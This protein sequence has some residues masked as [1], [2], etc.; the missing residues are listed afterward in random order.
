M[1]VEVDGKMALRVDYAHHAVLIATPRFWNSH[2]IHYMNVSLSHTHGNEGIMGP[3]APDSWLPKLRSG[4]SVGPK[5]T[6]L[7]DRFKALYKVFAESWRVTDE[8]SLFTYAPGT[9]TETFTDR[10]YPAL[11][12]PCTVK[13]QFELPVSPLPVNIDPE[14]AKQVCAGVTHPGLFQD[15]VF[16]VVTTGDKSFADGYLAEQKFK[17]DGTA[18]HV[19][20]DEVGTPGSGKI[21]ITVVVLG[22]RACCPVQRG[23]VTIYINGRAVDR[24]VDFDEVGRACVTLEDLKPGEYKISASYRR[25]KE[26]PYSSSTSPLVTYIVDKAITNEV[27]PI[28]RTGTFELKGTADGQFMFN[29]KAPNNEIILT[30]ERY[31]TKASAK[32]GIASVKKNAA[33]DERYDRRKSKS[34]QPYFVLQA[35]NREIIG[36]SEM[37]SSEKACETGIASVKKN[38]PNAEIDDQT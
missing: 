15:C 23:I 9:T 25:E 12:P 33:N 8:T 21:K 30:S 24:G 32:K 7:S 22:L 36:V 31:K 4:G 29:L 10:D 38:A 18:T 11:K 19:V 13:P 27:D 17:R 37:Y 26:C 28:E 35:A 34:G 2:N 3:I 6:K 5:P 20:V 16:D 14:D 1:G